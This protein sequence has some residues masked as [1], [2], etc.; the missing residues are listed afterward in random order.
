MMTHQ[1]RKNIVRAAKRKTDWYNG[2]AAQD[3]LIEIE[4]KKRGYELCH[5]YAEE[6]H[7]LSKLLE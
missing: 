6:G 2:E 3:K 5:F 7:K 4:C 1:I